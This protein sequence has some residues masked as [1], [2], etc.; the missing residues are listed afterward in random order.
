MCVKHLMCDSHLFQAGHVC[1]DAHDLVDGSPTGA[2]RVS[3]G[4]MSSYEDA[5]LLLKMVQ[6]CFVDQPII[7]D[8]SWMEKEKVTLSTSND[9]SETV[10]SELDNE[11]TVTKDNEW[12][13]ANGECDDSTEAF[14]ERRSPSK[15]ST[16]VASKDL[17][18][19]SLNNIGSIVQAS[20]F[21]KDLSDDRSVG[22]TLTDIV[23]Y[24]VK[25]CG[26]FSV[27]EW[28]LDHKGL[29]FDRH[30]MI[31]TRSG[32]TLTQKRCPQMCL[33]KPHIDLDAG[34]LTLTYEGTVLLFPN[35]YLTHVYE[36]N[37]SINFRHTIPNGDGNQ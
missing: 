18:V 5:D 23:I 25:S 15:S 17:S 28:G 20:S 10:Q 36:I 6:D 21:P 9:Q 4:Y 26:G 14:K 22:L 16:S 2:V 27:Q 3:F 34:L 8:V 29:K 11:Q 7:V 31:V 19:Q 12:R 37:Q 35:Y 24:P 33:I 32:V 13:T 1:G 30:W